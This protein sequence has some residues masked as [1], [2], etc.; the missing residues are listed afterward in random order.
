MQDVYFGA[1]ADGFSAMYVAA[2]RGFFFTGDALDLGSSPVFTSCPSYSCLWPPPA[3]S[4]N[5]ALCHYSLK[6]Y[7]QA[8]KYIEEIIERGI[9]EH[10]GGTALFVSLLFSVSTTLPVTGVFLLPEL[11]V[12]LT[13]EGI[14]IH[15]V[16]NTLVLHQTAL[17]EAFNL[18]A[19][20]EYQ[21]KNRKRAGSE[22]GIFYHVQYTVK[23]NPSSE[24]LS[25]CV[26]NDKLPVQP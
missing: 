1:A 15:S 5:I 4:Y 2:S 18:K 16:G 21:R 9:R 14:D 3:L 8:V 11:S 12:G 26:N 13:T 17:V 22:Q 10:P 19:A 7:N 24:N 25:S 6:N 23:K 20:I